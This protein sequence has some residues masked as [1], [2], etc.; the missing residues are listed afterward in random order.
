M[1]TKRHSFAFTLIELLVVIAIIAILAAI[2]FPVFAAAK[3][4]AKKTV[5]LSNEKQI[6]L[7]LQMYVGDFDDTLIYTDWFCGYGVGNGNVQWPIPPDLIYPY[8]KNAGI[9]TCPDF[10]AGYWA[11]NQP[12]LA[13]YPMCNST[14]ISS[15]SDYHM[16]YGVNGLLMLGYIQPEPYTYSALANVAS[17]GIFGESNGIDGSF[18]GWCANLGG[19]YHVYWTNSDPTQY[20]YYGWARH[21]NGSNFVYADSHAK[22]NIP[23]LLTAAQTS[24]GTPG[25]FRG[26][27]P[28]VRL[29]PDD[30]PCE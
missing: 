14:Q 12:T 21:N 29:D 5:C 19:G 28:G 24:G 15:T 20:W 6:G 17:T 10:Q 9:W 4:S 3:E 16:G 7:A 25:V 23:S 2:L 8:S 11:F 1:S 30:T 27:Y 18:V 13:Q 22:Y 26:Y